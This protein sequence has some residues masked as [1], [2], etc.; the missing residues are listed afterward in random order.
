MKV[1]YDRSCV[2][3]RPDLQTGEKVML[4]DQTTKRQ[5]LATVL[6]KCTEPR[7]YRVET[8]TGATNRRNSKLLK[9]IT[10]SAAEKLAPKY[11]YQSAIPDSDLNDI[12]EA[13]EPVT[14]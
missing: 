5:S 12:A 8:P 4:Q 11:N 14:N 7:S 1:Q 9:K 10:D 3:K 2:N 13:A 6:E